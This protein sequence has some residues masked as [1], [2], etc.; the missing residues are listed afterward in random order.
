[1]KKNLSFRETISV[2]SMLFG[3]FFGAGNL[4]FPA[5]M[6]QLAGR[7]VWIAIIGFC[8]TAVG[9]PL[10]GVAALGIS[11]SDGLQSLSGKVGRGY[12][13]FFTCALY[14]SI[15]PFFAIP[16]CATVPFTI[17]IEPLLSEGA[18]SSTAL[19]IFTLVFFALV[20]VF[21]L[22]PNGIM[23]W[24]GRILNP[25]FLVLL[26]V[27]V[28]RALI[29]PMGSIRSIDPSGN[30]VT[31]SFFTG[32]I[33]GYGTMDALAALA[34]GIVVVDVI[35]RL[36]VSEP[37]AIA[38]NTAG[39][40]IFSCL[41]MGLI[42]LAVTVVGTQSRALYEVC[43]NGGEVLAIIAKHYFGTAGDIVMAAIVT[44]A[45]LKTAIGLITSCSEAF[46]KMFKKGPSYRV[47]AVIFCIV[48]LLIANQGLTAI[49]SYSLPVLYL[50]YPLAITL[51]LLAL[52]GNLFN[53]SRTIYA[54]VTGLT[55]IAA[56]IDF[57]NAL[58]AN[59]TAALHMDG[60]VS[61]VR[62]VL[63]FSDIGLGWV[64]PA[65]LGLIIGLIIYTTKGKG[66]RAA[67]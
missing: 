66:R 59:V 9:M 48:S 42:Y 37:N 55:L 43:D 24:I 63:P 27:L 28:V 45:C 15:G 25:I 31:G 8:V 56:I 12:S 18:S 62:S 40:G 3:M 39:A 34:F 49:I 13:Y 52:F 23:T 22:F 14:L 58:P 20:L 26:G 50:L 36:G 6:G 2:T 46:E 54:W 33:E 41:L 17:G 30:Y 60:V 10:L 11:Q 61:T 35:K 47:W 44:F 7:N 5:L 38:R 29:D 53:H 19:L 67:A 64:C 21:S 65:L 57:F 1:M 51:I 16:R 32:F 4:I